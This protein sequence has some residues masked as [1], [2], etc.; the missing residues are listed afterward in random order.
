MQALKHYFDAVAEGKAR[1]IATVKKVTN[2]GL[3]R[4][5]A[6][7]GYYINDCIQAIN[8]TAYTVE[9]LGDNLSGKPHGAVVDGAEMDVIAHTLNRLVRR[10]ED[11]YGCTYPSAVWQQY[12]IL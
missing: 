11:A 1:T 5:I 3:R 4:I 6:L 2:K 10:V 9:I 7:K 12:D 8:L